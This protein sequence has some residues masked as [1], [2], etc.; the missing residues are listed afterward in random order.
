MRTHGFTCVCARACAPEVIELV[1]QGEVDFGIVPGSD[2]DPALEFRPLFPLSA[3]ADY[4]PRPPGATGIAADVIRTN[5]QVSV[6]HDGAGHVYAL[7]RGVGVSP[8]GSGLRHHHGGRFAGPDLSATSATVTAF[9]L[10]H[11]W[12]RSRAMRRRSESC[13]SAT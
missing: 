13:I 1:S 6:D 12:W 11:A 10:S 9:P 5:R 2:P 3:A 7:R 4:I 8:Q